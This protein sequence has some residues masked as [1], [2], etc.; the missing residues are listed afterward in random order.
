MEA[1]AWSRCKRINN[2]V[3]VFHMSSNETETGPSPQS[4]PTLLVLWF[5]RMWTR[6]APAVLNENLCTE[7]QF[8]NVFLSTDQFVIKICNVSV[9]TET[10]S[11]VTVVW[12]L[13]KTMQVSFIPLSS[14]YFKWLG[15]F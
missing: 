3:P 5:Y 10:K 12:T 1:L 4:G 13:K 14:F 2:I 7:Q 8:Q 9:S 6:R 15:L 11:T